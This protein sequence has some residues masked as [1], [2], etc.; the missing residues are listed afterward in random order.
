MILA[1]IGFWQ[2]GLVLIP[3]V[4]FILGFMIGKG[5]GYNKGKR[6]FRGF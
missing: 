5:V 3:V 2:L 1:T 4:L 6:D